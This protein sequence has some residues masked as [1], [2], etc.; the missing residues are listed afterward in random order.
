MVC[1]RYIAQLDAAF[2]QIVK[3]L[4][5]LHFGQAYGKIGCG[6][7]LFEHPLQTARPARTMKLET[8]LAVVVK[9][10]ERTEFPECGPNGNAKRKRG[11]KPDAR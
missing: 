3:I 1:K 9:R 6:H 4:V 11:Q 10:A 7:L 8:V 2:V 5:G